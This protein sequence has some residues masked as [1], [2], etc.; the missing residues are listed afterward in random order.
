VPCK[1]ACSE[2]HCGPK[3]NIVVVLWLGVACLVWSK[4]AANDRIARKLPIYA[5]KLP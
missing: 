2:W 4:R 1:L 3:A 5:G